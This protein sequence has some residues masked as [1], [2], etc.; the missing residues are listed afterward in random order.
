MSDFLGDSAGDIFH[1]VISINDGEY[2]WEA[3]QKN[4][5][6]LPRGWFELSR[7]PKEERL[8]FTRD[9]WLSKMLFVSKNGTSYEKRLEEFFEHLEDVEIFATQ[10]A[11]DQPF[12]LHM[13]YSLSDATGFFQ[14]RPP[15]S[16]DKI[17]TLK[18]QF[19]IFSFPPD[20]LAFLE[21]HD[22]FSKYTDTG[23]LPTAHMAR[24]Y[25]QLQNILSE[26]ML[27]R[28]DGQLINPSNLIPFYESF[29]LHSYQCFYSDWYP[30]NE[31]GNVYFSEHDRTISNFLNES[32]LEEN[33]AFSTFLGWLV[34]YLEDIWHL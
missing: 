28:P 16:P 33:L 27:V 32:K 25:Q 26:E 12:E 24:L 19:E 20:Y 15:A 30:E 21:I 14:G 18:K 2:S 22:G 9:F 6:L 3:L 1:K 7:L 4:M 31:M 17:A 23:V 8:E 13:V 10:T 5:P 29:G 11:P 34:F